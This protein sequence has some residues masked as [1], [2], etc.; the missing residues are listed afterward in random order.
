[1]VALG[2]GTE[3]AWLLT[4]ALLPTEQYSASPETVSALFPALR[5][6]SVFRLVG[7][8]M[9]KDDD[10][11]LYAHKGQTTLRIGLSA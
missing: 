11:H 3:V 8:G 7:K 9:A 5:E 6:L 4:C 10:I 1:M 2:G